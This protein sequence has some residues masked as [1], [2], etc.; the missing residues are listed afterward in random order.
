MLGQFFPSCLAQPTVANIMLSY[1]ALFIDY[2]LQNPKFER[3]GLQRHT[4]AE[5]KK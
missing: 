3:I 4:E 5:R 2:P 1:E